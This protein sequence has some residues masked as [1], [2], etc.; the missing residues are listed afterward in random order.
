MQIDIDSNFTAKTVEDLCS[1]LNV[2]FS[3]LF[4]TLQNQPNFHLDVDPSTPLPS[5]L[6]PKTIIFQLTANNTL[7]LAIFDGQNTN[8]SL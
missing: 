7:R 4:A 1:Q 3:K 2:V 8:H 6:P 5:N